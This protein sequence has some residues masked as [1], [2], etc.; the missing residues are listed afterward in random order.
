MSVVDSAAK[1]LPTSEVVGSILIDDGSARG[2]AGWRGVLGALGGGEL[3]GE[4]SSMSTSAASSASFGVTVGLDIVSDFAGIACVSTMTTSL[5]DVEG[6]CRSVP[7]LDE[8]D[9]FKPLL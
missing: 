3:G 6:L 7:L 9:A 8:S 4:E 2:T 1:A 5:S